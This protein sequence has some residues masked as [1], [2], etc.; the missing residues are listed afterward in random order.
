MPHIV[1]LNDGETFT[2]ANGCQ[3]ASAGHH[4]VERIEQEIKED[5]VKPLYV[6]EG[7]GFPNAVLT[8]EERDRAAEAFGLMWEHGKYTRAGGYIM[9][10]FLDDLY[11]SFCGSKFTRVESFC[12]CKWT[13]SE[14]YVVLDV[15]TTSANDAEQLQAT[16][17]G[18]GYTV[19]VEII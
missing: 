19:S 7:D 2:D 18:F 1:I 12:R 10:V 11:V 17:E 6:I 14:G 3:I 15:T 4:D 13:N 16:G 5:L 8:N 9:R